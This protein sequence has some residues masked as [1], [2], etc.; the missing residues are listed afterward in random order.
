MQISTCINE[1]STA[2]EKLETYGVP[3][4]RQKLLSIPKSKR[5]KQ[6]FEKFFGQIESDI[7][8]A[9]YGSGIP[10]P[11]PINQHFKAYL[12]NTRKEE[13]KKNY[14]AYNAIIRNIYEVISQAMGKKPSK[15]LRDRIAKG[16]VE[17]YPV[18][19]STGNKPYAALSTSIRKRANNQESKLRKIAKAEISSTDGSSGAETITTFAHRQSF[20]EEHGVKKFFEEFPQMQSAET[21]SF[22][23]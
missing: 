2:G 21:V 22:D 18:L 19:Q 12:T 9:G 23:I 20:I 14:A 3:S 15:E 6:H 8:E 17:E 1:P 11:F 5:P 16:L 10:Y 4:K 7:T 13:F